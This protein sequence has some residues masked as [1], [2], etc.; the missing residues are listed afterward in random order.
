[1]K[2][3]TKKPKRTQKDLALHVGVHQDTITNWK[4]NN[5]KL[6]NF[7]WESWKKFVKE[8]K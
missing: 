4:K 7:V 6:Y 3:D 1:M 8:E 5:P 2:I